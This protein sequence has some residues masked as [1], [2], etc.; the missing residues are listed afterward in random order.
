MFNCCFDRYGSNYEEGHYLR[1]IS[2]HDQ[3]KFCAICQEE[4][5]K[6]S[7]SP[8]FQGTSILDRFFIPKNE[9][10]MCKLTFKNNTEQVNHFV[11]DHECEF[12]WRSFR[13][14]E[15]KVKH[16]EYEHKCKFKVSKKKLFKSK[17]MVC[18]EVFQGSNFKDEKIA[19]LK[20]VHGGNIL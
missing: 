3:D 17:S 15:M 19:H 16:K 6:C 11:T 8:R 13:D 1:L 20:E 9:C 10:W 7:P 5:N 12:C 18:N 4:E 2:K 14:V